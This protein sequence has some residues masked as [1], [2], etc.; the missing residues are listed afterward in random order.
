VQF[1]VKDGRPQPLGPEQEGLHPTVLRPWGENVPAELA[2]AG[3]D[4]VEVRVPIE[5]RVSILPRNGGEAR[6]GDLT[7]VILGYEFVWSPTS[8]RWI[9]SATRI[10]CNPNEYHSLIELR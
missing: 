10:Y 6:K 7:K 9:P 4:A 1:T 5:H 8:G 2:M 3:R